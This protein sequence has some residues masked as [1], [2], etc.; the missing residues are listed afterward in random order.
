MDRRL[1]NLGIILGAVLLGS[2]DMDSTVAVPGSCLAIAQGAPLNATVP[3]GSSITVA[4][5]ADGGCPLPLVRNE[6]PSIIQ[7]DSVAVVTFRVTGKALGQ[8]R[9]RI[10]SGVDTLVTQVL[11]I[12]VVAP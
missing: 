2:C 4:A 1:A 10:R 11:S 7:M 3:L 12:T 5:T 8:G 9:I 6:T